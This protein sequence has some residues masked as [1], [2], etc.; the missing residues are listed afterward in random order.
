MSKER[1]KSAAHRA[2]RQRYQ[3][4]HNEAYF[5]RWYKLHP[6]LAPEGYDRSKTLH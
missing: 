3:E 6:E 4:K 1:S 5:R 2:K